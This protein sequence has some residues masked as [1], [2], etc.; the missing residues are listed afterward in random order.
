MFNHL[1]NMVC[2]CPS[3]DLVRDLTRTIVRR[4]SGWGTL[5]PRGKLS[6]FHNHVNLVSNMFEVESQ[7]GHTLTHI[8]IRVFT[9]FQY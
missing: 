4:N 1:V 2:P 9:T 3:L 7:V 8:Y 5:S 6:Q